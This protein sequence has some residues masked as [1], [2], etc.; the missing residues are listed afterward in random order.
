MKSRKV[1]VVSLSSLLLIWAG[2]CS[3]KPAP[4]SPVA[5]PATTSEVKPPVTPTPPVT[6]PVATP[7]VQIKLKDAYFDFDRSELK[8]EAREALTRDA[9]YLMSNSGARVLIEGHCDERGTNEYNLALGDRRARA[10][11]DFLVKYGVSASR[12]ETISYGEERPFA[13]GH[14]E[15]AWWQNRR[16]HFVER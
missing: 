15:S 11:M 7:A 9:E 12:I 4:A 8:L 16:A 13:L 14:D 10:A 3:K 1:L 6:P 2:G 5:P